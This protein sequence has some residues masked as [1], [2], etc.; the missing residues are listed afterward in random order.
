MIGKE[1]KRE[2]KKERKKDS[3]RFARESQLNDK[4]KYLSSLKQK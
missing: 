1:R 3:S 2:R 4:A